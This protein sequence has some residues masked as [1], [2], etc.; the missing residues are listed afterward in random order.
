MHA[1]GVEKLERDAGVGAGVA[2]STQLQDSTIMFMR[3]ITA[4][5]TKAMLCLKRIPILMSARDPM[6]PR[7]DQR[8]ATELLLTRYFQ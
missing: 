5:I 3:I 2:S 1:G 6:T 7:K 4:T 8:G